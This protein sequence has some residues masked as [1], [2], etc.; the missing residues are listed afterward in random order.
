MT[1][2]LIDPLLAHAVADFGRQLGLLGFELDAQGQA[3]LRMPSGQTLRLVADGTQVRV[4][5]ECPLP[6]E[7]PELLERAL[8]SAEARQRG[9]GVQLGLRGRGADQVLLIARRLAARRCSGPLLAREF[10][11]LLDWAET[12]QRERPRAGAWPAAFRS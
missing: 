5:I 2:L 7:G 3:L 4:Q 10:E 1:T 12:L 9:G 8:A 6:H 11:G